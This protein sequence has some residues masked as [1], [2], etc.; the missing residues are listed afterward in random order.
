MGMPQFQLTPPKPPMSGGRV[1]W[2]IFC[3]A[4]AGFWMVCSFLLLF[5]VA[6]ILLLLFTLPAMIGSCL[7]ILV[8][9]G[10]GRP[11]TARVM[12]PPGGPYGSLPPMPPPPGGWGAGPGA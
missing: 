2:I 8:P 12:P 4:W 7:M 5:S 1:A 10:K 6:G 9:V 11:A 3:L